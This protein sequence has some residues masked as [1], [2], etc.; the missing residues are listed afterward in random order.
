MYFDERDKNYEYSSYENTYNDIDT[1]KW[2]NDF[3]IDINNLNINN[4]N[5]N[6]ELFNSKEGL[7]KGNMFKNEYNQYKNYV[8]KVLVKG[9]RDELLLKIQELTFKMI[10]L[11][12]YL[13]INPNNNEIFSEYKETVDLLKKHKE[14]Y[15][16]NYGPLCLESNINFNSFLWN[17]DPW[18]WINE[19][20]NN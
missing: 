8:F 18:P 11:G 1:K 7:N 15:E 5:R 12:L 19:G 9:D 17:K 14:K 13:D 10:D 6:N 20:G 16:N 4:F 3:I 2:N